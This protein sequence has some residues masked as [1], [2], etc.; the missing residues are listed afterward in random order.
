MC[1]HVCVCVFLPIAWTFQNGEV[2]DGDNRCSSSNQTDLGK[3]SIIHY[4]DKTKSV[5]AFGVCVC[6]CV[7]VWDTQCLRVFIYVCVS[8]CIYMY[9]FMCVSVYAC[10]H[11]CLCVSISVCVCVCVC[12]RVCVRLIV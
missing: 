2:K 9:V 5:W 4:W 11:V 7:C 10:F 1:V 8:V 6:V 3:H 12:V